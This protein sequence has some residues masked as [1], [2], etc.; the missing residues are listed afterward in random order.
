MKAIIALMFVFAAGAAQAAAPFCVVSNAGSQCYYYDLNSC[1]QAARTMQ[2]L[3]T[4]NVQQN[5]SPP[6]IQVQ[7]RNP[8]AVQQMQLPDFFEAARKGEEAGIQRRQA[9]E[10]SELNRLQQQALRQQIAQR[11]ASVTPEPDGKALGQIVESSSALHHACGLA[12][13]LTGPAGMKLTED[14]GMQGF[15]CLMYAQGAYA[16]AVS[17]S[18]FSSPDKSMQ[19]CTPRAGTNAFSLVDAL[20]SA[21]DQSEPLL[22]PSMQAQSLLIAAFALLSSCPPTLR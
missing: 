6:P 5:P 9:R 14:E 15:A 20:V 8:S 17:T 13:A 3:C 21:G 4:A 12:Q 2:G 7:P 10:Q 22:A 11:E 16:V 1:Q 19:F 18:G